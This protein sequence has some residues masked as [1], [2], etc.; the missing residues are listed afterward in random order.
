MLRRFPFSGGRVGP[1]TRK[2]IASIATLMFLAAWIWG[3]IALSAFIPDAW[4]TKGLYFAVAGVGWGAPLV[5]LFRWA[6]RGGGART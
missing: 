3:A 4:W 1:R 2:A 6:E 5:P